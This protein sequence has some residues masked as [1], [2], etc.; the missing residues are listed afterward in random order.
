MDRVAATDIP[1]MTFW[2]DRLEMNINIVDF[3]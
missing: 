2:K 3:R 1:H